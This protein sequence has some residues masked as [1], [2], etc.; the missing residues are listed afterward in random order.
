MLQTHSMK[1]KKYKISSQLK[2]REEYEEIKRES[3]RKL[4]E[5]MSTPNWLEVFGRKYYP[6]NW[7]KH[8]DKNHP[9]RAKRTK[10]NNDK[11]QRRAKGEKVAYNVPQ[12]KIP[13]EQWDEDGDLI[14]TFPNAK[15]AAEKLG[16][17]ESTIIRC[18]R[19]EHRTSNGYIWKFKITKER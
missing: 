7:I 10:E 14:E 18:A 1:K 3:K 11:A 5:I 2:S 19:G 17:V 12:T 6:D 8:L 9:E 16:Y 13:I 4:E 15:A